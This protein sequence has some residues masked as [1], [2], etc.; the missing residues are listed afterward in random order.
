MSGTSH[1]EMY[2]DILHV[3]KLKKNYSFRIKAQQKIPSEIGRYDIITCL[4]A[5]FHHKWTINDWYF[6]L[7]DLIKNHCKY[8]SE[9]CIFFQVNRNSAWEILE[10]DNIYSSKKEIKE[11]KFFENH[12]LRIKI[13]I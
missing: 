1:L 10:K 13:R 6:F 2:E 8:N 4:G 11:W 12:I 7:D 9:C 3:L 5:M